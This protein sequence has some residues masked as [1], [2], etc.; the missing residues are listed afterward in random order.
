MKYK[1][2]CLSEYYDKTLDIVEFG[3]HGGLYTLLII[4]II[5]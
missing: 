2:E 5:E 3:Y 1:L 4:D